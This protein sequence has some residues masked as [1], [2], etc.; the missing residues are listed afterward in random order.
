MGSRFQNKRF[1]II[2]D[3]EGAE[4]LM[5]KGASSILDMVPKPIWLM[6]IS[7]S[8]HQPKG[9]SINPNLS[10]TFHVFWNRGYEAWTADKQCR[11]IYPNEIEEIVKSGVDTLYTNNFLFIEKGKKT[12]LISA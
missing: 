5:L 1:F 10:Y 11:I 4:Q 7:I 12:E 9:V 8:Q 3:I 6:E 2:V